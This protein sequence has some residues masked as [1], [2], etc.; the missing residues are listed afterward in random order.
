MIVSLGPR[1]DTLKTSD[2]VTG[3]PKH[4]TS[5]QPPST[6]GATES[7]TDHERETP[8]EI[9]SKVVALPV[10]QSSVD[11]TSPMLVKQVTIQQQPTTIQEKHDSKG[12]T[13]A[14]AD[15]TISKIVADPL[16][17]IFEDKQVRKKRDALEKELKALKKSHDKEKMKLTSQKSGDLT[18][19]IKKS[20]FGMGNK[21]VK[22]FSSKNMADMNIRIPPCVNPDGDNA[23]DNS[24][25]AERLKQVCRDHASSYRDV[26]EKY[27]EV[28]YNLADDLLRQSQ[29]NQMKQMKVG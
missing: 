23:C 9:I 8:L 3:S 5:I 1:K 16:E 29:E 11:R 7:S 13:T 14:G 12:H 17:K 15:H 24:A 18:D 4:R 21:L 27:H 26:L 22:R 19:G 10:A 2:N 28:I 20:K 25:H 6:T